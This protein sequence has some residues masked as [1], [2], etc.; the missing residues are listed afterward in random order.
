MNPFL[1]GPAAVIAASATTAYAALHPRSKI[2]GTATSATDSARKLALTFDDGPNPRVTP[3]LLELL[4]RYKARATFFVIGRY[5]DECP[6]LFKETISGGHAVGNHTYTHRNLFFRR[7][8]DI[9]EEMRRCNESIFKVRGQTPVW[10]RPPY[11][12]RNPWVI[13]TARG[14]GQRTV[15]WSVL[16]GDWRAESAEWLIPRIGPIAKHA[17]RLKGVAERSQRSNGDIL[18]LHDGDHRFL[19]GDREHTLKALEYWLPRWRDLGLEFV[20]IDE[21]VSEPAE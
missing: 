21:A 2:F 13:P 7:T 15:L 10:F 20:T 19:N 3:K 18:C 8:A 5:V 17:E 14:L 1:A 16:P 11:G 6:E 9:A 4:A 12:L